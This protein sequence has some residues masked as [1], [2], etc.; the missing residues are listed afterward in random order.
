MAHQYPIGLGSSLVCTR[1]E[2]HIIA[3]AGDIAWPVLLPLDLNRHPSSVFIAPPP[4]RDRCAVHPT[5][6]EVTEYPRLSQTVACL[7]PVVE[8]ISGTTSGL[9]AYDALCFS[10]RSKHQQSTAICGRVASVVVSVDIT[11]FV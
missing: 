6:C 5:P 11:M 10:R 1:A 4:R 2:T 8:P 7:A 3:S 9:V